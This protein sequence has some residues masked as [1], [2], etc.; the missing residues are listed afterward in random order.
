MF[1]HNEKNQFST[2]EICS[3]TSFINNWHNMKSTKQWVS[4]SVTRICQLKNPLI[5]KISALNGIFCHDIDLPSRYLSLHL[6]LFFFVQA[7][8]QWLWISHYQF[9]D[10]ITLEVTWIRE[11]FFHW[12]KRMFCII[13]EVSGGWMFWFVCNEN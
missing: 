4:E 2:L 13:W 1:H 5:N 3:K 6:S 11:C 9:R 8:Y 7:T 12:S 10:V